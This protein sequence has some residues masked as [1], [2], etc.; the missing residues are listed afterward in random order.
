MNTQDEYAHPVGDDP[1][2][3]ESYYFNFVD[4][5]TKIA[6]FT[7]MGFRAKDGWAD[8]LHVVYLGGDRLAFTYGRRSIE[9]DDQELS[10]GGLTLVRGEP[11]RNWRIEYDGPA[12]DIADGAILIT[13]SKERPDGWFKPAT[14]K[15]AIDFE[16]LIEPHYAASGEHG[17]FEQTG[18]VQGTIELGEESW[19]VSGFGVRDKSWGPR[20]WQG[21]SSSSD[22]KTDTKSTGHAR[23][24]TGFQ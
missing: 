21:G 6:M 11:F 17:H 5:E 13:P 4:P 24:S 9:P 14:L 15:M 10:V 2:W 7:R 3:S 20:S 19:S 18:K 23:S 12:Q 8:G 1:A 16:A 22:E